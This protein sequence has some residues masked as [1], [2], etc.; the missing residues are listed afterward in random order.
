MHKVDIKPNAPDVAAVHTVETLVAS[1]KFMDCLTFCNETLLSIHQQLPR[2]VRYVAD[3]RRWIMTHGALKLNFA[4]QLDSRSPA[5]TASNLYREVVHTGAVSPNT[6]TNYL[7][8]IEHLGYI[9]AQPRGD[10]RLRAYRMSA[11]SERMFY[12]YL[13]V[14]LNGLDI[15]D[16][17]KRSDAAQSDPKILTHMHPVFASLMLKDAAYYHPPA[18]IAPLVHSTVGISVLNEMT[19][20]ADSEYYDEKEKVSVS[21]DSANAMAQRYGTSRGNIARLLAKVRAAGDYGQS[22]KG[23]WVSKQ[24]LQEY[25]RWQ[26]GKLANISAAYAHAFKAREISHVNTV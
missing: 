8:E 16:G 22:D 5:L 9:E 1:P 20:K 26:A 14:H 13:T 21:L 17:H 12:H 2:E 25:Y 3:M 7:K 23:H 11:F 15:L 10:R 4:H 24:L 18:S 6:V 19:R